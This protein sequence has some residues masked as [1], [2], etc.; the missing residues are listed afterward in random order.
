MSVSPTVVESQS[1]IV[2]EYVRLEATVT[3]GDSLKVVNLSVIQGA[4]GMRMKDW[5]PVTFTF[6]GNIATVATP[7]LLNDRIVVV[8]GGIR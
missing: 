3:T 5:S 4:V 1:A 6:A 8:A 2:G 7:G